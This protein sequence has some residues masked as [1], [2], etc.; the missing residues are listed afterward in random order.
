MPRSPEDQA[1][2]DLS[3]E[4]KEVILEARRTERLLII[5]NAR[6]LSSTKEDYMLHM[7]ELHPDMFNR[8][9]ADLSWEMISESAEIAQELAGASAELLQ[10]T[11][12][13]LQEALNGKENAEAVLAS[14]QISYDLLVEWVTVDQGLIIP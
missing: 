9:E 8:D 7:M 3:P 5:R 11:Q 4:E 1:F 2:L 6:A 13:A 12:E 14:L 10:E